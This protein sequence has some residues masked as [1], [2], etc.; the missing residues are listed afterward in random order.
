MEFL[1]VFFV[2][3][4]LSVV[5]ISNVRLRREKRELRNQLRHTLRATSDHIDTQ[6]NELRWHR[7]VCE[8]LPLPIFVTDNDKLLIYAN[9]ASQTEFG[10]LVIGEAAI[11]GLRD[12]H[13]ESLLDEALQNGRTEPQT[14]SWQKKHFF[15]RVDTWVNMNGVRGGTV[16]LMQD[17][18]ELKRLARARRDMASNLSHELRTPLA[19][20][21]LMAETLLHG[22]LEEPK[23]GKRMV[24]R[25]AA[26]ND[27]MIR[28]IEDLTAL[29][30]IESRR[31]PLR[32]ER[33]NLRLLAEQRINRLALQQELKQLQI[34]LIGP[35]E[36]IIELDSERFGQVLTNLLDNA[37]KFSPKGGQIKVIINENDEAITLAIC[38]EGAGIMPTDLPRIFERFYKGD[39]ARTRS[40]KAGT[41]LGLAIVKHL[42][43]A[44]NG[45]IKA[46]NNKDGGAT[47]TI[48]LFK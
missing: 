21:K 20:I 23:F 33:L 30:W 15:V 29:S 5:V 37:I 19:S 18:T 47:F 34:Q 24:M 2:T 11:R 42:V 36:P 45:S 26:E 14:I 44:H 43:E 7:T 9:H 25:I 46:E 17:V 40:N 12:H 6:Q 3:F 8:L 41:G 22:A 31:V 13:L 48:T 39:Q 32:L 27:A 35:P 1:L 4:S 38:D 16:V 10:D 28:L